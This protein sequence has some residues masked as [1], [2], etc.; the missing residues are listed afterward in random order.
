[1][2]LR[3]AEHKFWLI[4]T[5]EVA[6]KLQ[7]FGL[8]KLLKQLWP[9]TKLQRLAFK[10]NHLKLLEEGNLHAAVFSTDFPQTYDQ[11]TKDMIFSSLNSYEVSQSMG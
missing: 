11:D 2:K 3:N 7:R 6:A 4:E 5:V 8:L 9:A 10:E 1:M